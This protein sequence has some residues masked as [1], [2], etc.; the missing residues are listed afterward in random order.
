MASRKGKGERHLGKEKGERQL[1]TTTWGFYLED[2][3]DVGADALLDHLLLA[4]LHLPGGGGDLGDLRL[5]LDHRGCWRWLWLR[6]GR[7]QQE[8]SCL[9]TLSDRLK[10]AESLLK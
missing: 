3:V 7:V 1:E 10:P 2:V 6:R 4:V 8:V 5:L 9:V